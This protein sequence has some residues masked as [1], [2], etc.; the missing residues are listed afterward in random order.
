MTTNNSVQTI[1]CWAC[2]GVGVVSER[3]NTWGK[4]AVPIMKHNTKHTVLSNPWW[5]PLALPRSKPM[6]R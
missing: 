4:E 1:D 6:A 2:L 3:I 5:V